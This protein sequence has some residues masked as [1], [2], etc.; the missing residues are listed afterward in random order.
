V[1]RQQ[2]KDPSGS[3]QFVVLEPVP[4]RFGTEQGILA[5]SRNRHAA[6]LWL[7]FIVSPEAQRLIDE[8][9]PLTSSLYVRGSAIEQELR[10]KKLS[11]VSWDENPKLEQWISKI[12]E[13]YGFPKASEA[14]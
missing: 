3:T 11:L 4:V 14:K 1:K 7:Q 5:S 9:E 12:F 8:Y 13:A 10:G 6:L 2:R